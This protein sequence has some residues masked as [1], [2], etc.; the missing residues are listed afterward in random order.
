FL[1]ATIVSPV[2]GV[3][4]ALTDSY[5]GS[6]FL[7]GFS[8]EAISDPTNGRVNYVNAATAAAQNLTFASSSSFIMRADHTSVLSAPGPG[9]NSVRLNTLS[10]DGTIFTSLHGFN[11][12]HMPQGCGTWPAV[13]TFG[14]P[15]PTLGEMDILEGVSDET[16]NPATLQTSAG[17]TMPASRAETGVELLNDCNVAANSNAGCGVQIQNTASYGPPFNANGGGW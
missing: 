3:R 16:F 11:I 8:Y 6:G 7:S 1:L 14:D 12:R 4:Y 15:W 9:R 17:C 5:V 2:V 13:R 10:T